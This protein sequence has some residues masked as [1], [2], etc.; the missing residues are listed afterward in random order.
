[1]HII[2]RLEN[3]ESN[4][5]LAKEMGVAHS[6]IS[7]IFKDR[8]KIKVIFEKNSLK[9]KRAK[10]S[11]YTDIEEALLNWFKYQR[12]RNIP[13]SGP[14]LQKKAMDF[15][16]GLGYDNFEC[17]L[18][19]IQ[20]FRAR[21]AIVG[22]RVCGESSDVSQETVD[23]WL[24]KKWPIL[25]QGYE[26]EEIYNADETGLF[27]NMMP[28][29]TLKFKGEKCSGGKMNKTRIT[30]LVTA[31]MTGSAKE[32]LLVIGRSKNPHCFKSVRSLPVLYESN[33]KAWMTSLIWEKWL[34][35]WDRQLKRQKKK[36]LLL[37]DNCPAHCSVE[38]L[39]CIKLVFLPPNVTSVLQPMDMGVIKSLKAQYR[40][41]QIVKIIPRLDKGEKKNFNVLDA[42]LLID[43]AW[44]NVSRATISHCFSHGGFKELGPNLPTNQVTSDNNSIVALVQELDPSL[45]RNQVEDFIEVDSNVA[46]C[47]QA[48]DDDIL[49]EV[50]DD[51][52]DDSDE[53]EEEEDE[54]PTL[55]EALIAATTLKKFFL[56]RD[57]FTDQHKEN[58]EKIKSVMQN[59]LLKNIINKKQSKITDFV[60]NVSCKNNE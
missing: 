36:I 18:S 51:Q 48:T 21:N 52:N 26:S 28:N 1:M 43:E 32:K 50:R 35:Q 42:I 23:E 33:T 8:E 14:I 24:E 60:E 57:E 58:F 6:T 45:A 30:V 55:S 9:V 31:N 17:S 10:F 56:F 20:R 38:N 41:L 22:G 4:A 25:S 34:R 47:A 27:F 59:L 11:D 44:Q 49:A 2:S 5:S 53:L 7:T 16:R 12:T 37:V 3:G 19:W 15:A 54:E 40:K 29:Q 46:I 13:I 39:N